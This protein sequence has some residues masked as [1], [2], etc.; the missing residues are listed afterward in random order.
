MKSNFI[1]FLT[2]VLFFLIAPPANAQE[3]SIEPLYGETDDFAEYPGTYFVRVKLHFV[4]LGSQPTPFLDNRAVAI[5]EYLNSI[6]VPFGIYFLAIDDCIPNAAPVNCSGTIPYEINDFPGQSPPSSLLCDHAIDI[7]DL[8]DASGYSGW[9]FESPSLRIW[10]QGIYNGLPAS[11]TPVLIHEIGHALGLFHT[12]RGVSTADGCVNGNCPVGTP[13]GITQCHCCED[14]VCD[15]EATPWDIVTDQNCICT[16]HPNLTEN[17]YRN[18]MIGVKPGTTQNQTTLCMDR[19]SSGQVRR[20][21]AYLE[22]SATLDPAVVRPASKS[23]TLPAGLY[24][25]IVVESGQELEIN[26]PIEMLPGAS[27]RVK[28][29]A[30]LRVKSTITGGCGGMWQGIIVE[31]S[32][33]YSQ[34]PANQGKVIVNMTGKI[35]HALCAIEAQDPDATA[36]SAT[37]GGIVEIL[38]GD[39]VNNTTGICFGAY[40]WAGLA[41]ASKIYFADFT[42]TEDYRGDIQPI[43]L[44]VTGVVQLKVAGGSFRDIRNECNSPSSM[45]LGIDLKNAGLNLSNGTLFQDLETGLSADHLTVGNG[46]FKVSGAYFKHCYTDIL[47]ISTGSFA[48]TGS[49]FLLGKPGAC[50]SSSSVDVTGVQLKGNTTGFKF[51]GNDFYYNGSELPQETLIGTHCENTGQGMNNV[52]KENTFSNLTIS[53]LAAKDNGYIQGLLY[54][55]NSNAFSLPDTEPLHIDFL[56]TPDGTIK[57]EQLDF[58]GFNTILPTGNEFSEVGYTFKNEG[59]TVVSYYYYDDPGFPEQDPGYTGLVEGVEGVSVNQPNCIDP[60]ENPPCPEPYITN[61]KSLFYTNKQTWL[62]GKTALPLLTNE[63]E[64]AATGR[65]IDS[66]RF[67]LDKSANRILSYYSLDTSVVKADSIVTWLSLTETWPASL[68]LA[69]HYFFS[70]DFNTFDN[71]WANMPDTYSLV[72]DSPE[73]ADYDGLTE[74]FHAMRPYAGSEAALN[75]LPRTV[76]DSLQTWAAFCSEPGYLAQI[77]LWRNGIRTEADCTAGL[78]ERTDTPRNGNAK[79]AFENAFRVY[80]NPANESLVIESGESTEGGSV[81]LLNLQGIPVISQAWPE[82]SDRVEIKTAHLAAG[83]YL[84]EIRSAQEI[85]RISKIIINH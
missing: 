19:F 15:T 50:P 56:V 42:I 44:D 6:Y 81:T 45:A 37:G 21:R 57:I 51:S 83:I 7:F 39:L 85:I 58:G 54:L 78:S 70:G 71:L 38:G 67:E 14:N 12:Y 59:G 46:S 23:G 16:S 29:G 8:G 5:M 80:P 4:N 34:T 65:V 25:N 61:E 66:L 31:G 40:N 76:L 22:L 11:Q 20:M 18:Y 52:I 10:V 36:I 1:Y 84:V 72:D 9:A 26:V 75:R 17:Q 79:P 55:C 74:I 33:F 62:A 30:I 63:E 43:F 41:N 49:D 69:R 77:L 35:E 68:R 64:I 24:E 53:N 28:R 48:I 13:S 60:C 73:L 27:I 2:G 32:T 47:S 3:N 82:L